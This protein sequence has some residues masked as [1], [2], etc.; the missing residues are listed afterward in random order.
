M[1]GARIGLDSSLI[2]GHADYVAS[3]LKVLK[4]DKRAILT[5]ASMA[6]KSCNFLVPGEQE[7]QDEDAEEQEQQQPELLPA[8]G[9]LAMAM[10]ESAPLR[11]AA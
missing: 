11:L 5:A 10:A 1:I 2:Q 4:Q 8:E 7:A 3:W 9:E 6:Q